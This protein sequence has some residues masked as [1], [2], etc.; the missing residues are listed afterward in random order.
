MLSLAWV[1]PNPARAVAADGAA[2]ALPE[3]LAKRDASG[4]PLDNVVATVGS[5][6]G[7]ERLRIAAAP[8]EAS[9]SPELADGEDTLF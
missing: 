5:A 9:A 3:T 7:A 8:A 2:R 1:G 4:Q 6:V